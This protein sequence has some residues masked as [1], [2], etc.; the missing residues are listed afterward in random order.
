MWYLAETLR[1]MRRFDE[2]EPVARRTLEIWRAHF[3]M[4]HEWTA[5]GLISLA[6]IRLAQGDAREAAGLAECAVK[7]LQ[8]AFGPQHA[9]VA[10]TLDL[11]GRAL[12]ALGDDGAAEPLFGQARAIQA[13]LAS[14]TGPPNE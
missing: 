10:S 4:D 5:W 12:H 1:G 9:V 8:N 2:A 11:Q 6:E 14:P 13:A 7:A 3:G